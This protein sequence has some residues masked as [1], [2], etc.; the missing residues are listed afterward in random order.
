MFS[1]FQQTPSPAPDIEM[2]RPG[3][4]EATEESMPAGW[5]SIDASEKAKILSGIDSNSY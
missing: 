3:Q 4:K 1:Y 2:S 5:D